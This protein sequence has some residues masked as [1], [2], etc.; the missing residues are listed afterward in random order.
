MPARQPRPMFYGDSNEE[1]IIYG[2]SYQ[3]CCICPIF[4]PRM[5]VRRSIKNIK[6]V[7]WGRSGLINGMLR[8][9]FNWRDL[10]SEN[11]AEKMEGKSFD[12]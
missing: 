7:K 3:P 4:K 10:L 11:F 6:F 8:K 12:F 1:S 2:L 5:C 9:V